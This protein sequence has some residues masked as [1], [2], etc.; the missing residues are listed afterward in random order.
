MTYLIPDWM[1]EEER[2]RRRRTQIGEG[3]ETGERYEKGG[4]EKSRMG[5]GGM[6]KR[7]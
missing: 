7:V 1:V 3:R 2:K 5:K 4:R 6:R